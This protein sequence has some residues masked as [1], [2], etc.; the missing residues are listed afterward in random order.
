MSGWTA[1][2]MGL[3][4]VAWEALPLC[5]WRWKVDN[6]FNANLMDSVLGSSM[7]VYCLADGQSL[8]DC[9]W[10]RHVY[11]MLFADSLIFCFDH[12]N[13]IR[14]SNTICNFFHQKR[15]LSLVTRAPYISFPAVCCR[16]F[17]CYS[18]FG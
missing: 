12:R 14:I 18:S 15:W 5:P 3:P 4:L 7:I 11:I 2:Q 17:Q 10:F 16:L 6:I 9:S 8:S 13:I 1:Q